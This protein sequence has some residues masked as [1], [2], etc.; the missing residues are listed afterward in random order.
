MAINPMHEITLPTALCTALPYAASRMTSA[1]L[2]PMTAAKPNPGNDGCGYATADR[3]KDCGE[4]DPCRHL[5]LHDAQE[6]GHS[7]SP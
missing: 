5:V 3:M 6:T 7:S 1:Q 2:S 4:S